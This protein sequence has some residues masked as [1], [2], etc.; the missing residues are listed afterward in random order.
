MSII[1]FTLLALILILTLFATVLVN[2]LA[3]VNKQLLVIVAGKEP[4]PE[5]ALRALVALSKSPQ[6][7]LKGIAD[8]K[9]EA[10]KPTNTD[11]V[12]EIGG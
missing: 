2:R 1:I 9:K 12:M 5:S 8:G 11:Y 4:K 7:K 10:K 3:E 6:K